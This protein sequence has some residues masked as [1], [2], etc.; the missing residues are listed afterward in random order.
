M[1]DLQRTVN[2][3]CEQQEADWARQQKALDVISRLQEVAAQL[4]QLSINSTTIERVTSLSIK[5]TQHSAYISTTRR[6]STYL[7]TKL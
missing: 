3:E 1:T 6:R 4:E 7:S 5:F 2:T